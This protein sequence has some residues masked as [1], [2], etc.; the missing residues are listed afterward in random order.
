MEEIS[1]TLHSVVSKYSTTFMIID[2][3]DEFQVSSSVRAKF[4]SE[5]FNLQAKATT[6]LFVASRPIPEITKKFEGKSTSLEIRANDEDVRRYLHENMLQL[7][8][9]VLK[10]S[11]M[12]EEIIVEIFKAVD[13]M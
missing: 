12:Q 8:Q 2:A 5:I 11:V 1:K 6:N 7:Q 4:L 10:N 9:C 3:L 13:G